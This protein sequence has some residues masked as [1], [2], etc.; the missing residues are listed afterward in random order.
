MSCLVRRDESLLVEVESWF[1]CNLRMSISVAQGLEMASR[2]RFLLVLVCPL[3]VIEMLACIVRTFK[4]IHVWLV[5]V[6]AVHAVTGILTVSSCSVVFFFC[7][8]NAA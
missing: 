6:Y 2:S 5:C 4:L 3:F 1:Q 7:F 8:F